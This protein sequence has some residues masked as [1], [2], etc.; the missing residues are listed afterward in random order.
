MRSKS[1]RVR[2]A[3][4]IRASRTH[5]HFVQRKILGDDASSPHFGQQSPAKI[6]PAM[7]TGAARFYSHPL[8]L[9]KPSLDF[10]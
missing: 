3:T 10:L 1:T 6:G 7:L 8:S 5:P 4:D 9:S 2:C